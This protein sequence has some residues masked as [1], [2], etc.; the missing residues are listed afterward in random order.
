MLKIEF[1]FLSFVLNK[2]VTKHN[3]A[4]ISLGHVYKWLLVFARFSKFL[5]ILQ[6][7]IFLEFFQVLSKCLCGLHV[8]RNGYKSDIYKDLK[9]YLF[10][11]LGSLKIFLPFVFCSYYYVFHFY[12]WLFDFGIRGQL[13]IFITVL[14]HNEEKYLF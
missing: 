6:L 9:T 2:T 10:V 4:W 8:T 5:I 7:L 14:K 3:T 13:V 12:K 1:Y 11:V